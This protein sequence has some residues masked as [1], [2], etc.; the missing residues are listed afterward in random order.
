MQRLHSHARMYVCYCPTQ[1]W[2]AEEHAAAPAPAA[3]VQLWQ[4]VDAAAAHHRVLAELK[5]AVARTELS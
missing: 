5:A 3:D 1:R 4:M 2:S